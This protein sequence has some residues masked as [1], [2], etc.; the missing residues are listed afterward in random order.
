MCTPA[1]DNLRRQLPQARFVVVGSPGA[2]QLLAG[3]PR[4][5]AFVPDTTKSQR[6][7]LLAGTRLGRQLRRDYGPFELAFT[8]KNSFSARWLL[9]AAGARHRVGGRVNWSDLLLTHAVPAASGQHYVQWYNQIVNGYFGS[10]HAA[11]PLSLHVAQPS[12]FARPTAG[13][14]PG[15]AY[16]SARRWDADRLGAVAVALS[17]DFDVLI[18]G[19]PQEREQANTIEMC[20]RQ[21]GV[22]GFRNLTGQ[23]VSEMVSNMAGMKLYIGHD[24]GTTH[25]AAALGVPTVAIYGSTAPALAY[26]W[27][28]SASRIVRRTVPCAPCNR[29]VCP[30][31]HHA[32]MQQITVHEVLEAA[33]SLAAA[34]ALSDA[35]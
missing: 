18:L 1:L 7:R 11:G 31:K 22:T 32:C 33:S 4:W 5:D 9:K 8:F 3:D 6:L 24:S 21:A 10:Q 2:G 13:I 16:G 23:S 27:R 25:M 17:R 26:P 34:A 14:A 19:G 20:L 35:A 30:L 29:R 12:A 28:H 15:S